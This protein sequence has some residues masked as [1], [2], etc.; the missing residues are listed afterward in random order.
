MKPRIR[1]SIKGRAPA[2]SAVA[3]VVHEVP[4][5]VRLRLS[6][7]PAPAGRALETRLRKLRGVK[8]ASAR[9]K[10]RSVVVEFAPEQVTVDRILVSVGGSEPEVRR[11]RVSAVAAKR[12]AS[13]ASTAVAPA[14]RRD[15]EPPGALLKGRRLIWLA[16]LDA[17]SVRGRVPYLRLT[18]GGGSDTSAHSSRRMLPGLLALLPAILGLVDALLGATTPLGIARASLEV[19]KFLGEVGALPVA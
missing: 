4:G 8:S 15:R 9:P 17:R 5:R 13:A 2:E 10:T 6:A 3:V 12:P 16:E 1:T 11:G 7:M 14:A 18:S 19:V